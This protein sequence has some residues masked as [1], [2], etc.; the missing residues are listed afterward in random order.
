MPVKAKQK[1]QLDTQEAF[2]LW[3]M[4]RVRYDLIETVNIIKNFIHD[5]DFLVVVERWM[6]KPME[7]QITELE[8][9]MNDLKINL[10]RRPPKSARPPANIGAINDRYLMKLFMTLL[11]E[12]LDMHMRAIQTSLTNEKVRAM[13]RRFLDAEIK[14]YDQ[15]LKY[16]KSKSWIGSPPNYPLS[17]PGIAE[18]INTGEAYHLFDH[19]TARYDTLEI[20]QIYEHYSKDSDF[21]AILRKGIRSSLEK[22]INIL[23]KELDH[24]GIPLMDRPPKSVSPPD[25][26][27][28]IEDQLMFRDVFTGLQYMFSLHAEALKQNTTND[29]LRTLYV[30]FLHEELDVFDKLAKY[31]KL[32]GWLR[33]TPL[34]PSG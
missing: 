1:P 14:I 9:I 21:A 34:Y 6:S 15:A 29:R 11:Q 33:S 26:A 10:P 25:N 5:K 23:E 4:L 18:K 31:G 22:Q 20:S 8:K 13:F 30:K 24:F 17:P 27:E 19:L 28:I 12:N 3:D 16:S 7:G 32:K 2:N